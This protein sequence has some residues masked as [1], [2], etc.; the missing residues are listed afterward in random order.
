RNRKSHDSTHQKF[1]LFV[2][3]LARRF[4]SKTSNPDAAIAEFSSAI[5]RQSDGEDIAN[6]DTTDI[7]GSNQRGTPSAPT[8]QQFQIFMK[9]LPRCFQSKTLPDEIQVESAF[10]KMLG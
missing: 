3:W 10:E 5:P 7:E 8:P 6:D 9:W 4:E 2:K 1:Q